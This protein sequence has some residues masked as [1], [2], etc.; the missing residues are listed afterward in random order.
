MHDRLA[1]STRCNDSGGCDV[2]NMMYKPLPR[3]RG[4]TRPL[5]VLV[6]CSI[7]GVCLSA[8]PVLA[9]DTLFLLSSSD[10]SPD[11]PIDERSPLVVLCKADPVRC[12]AVLAERMDALREM[13]QQ[14]RAATRGRTVPRLEEA[15][16]LASVV[17]DGPPEAQDGAAARLAWLAHR[18]RWVHPIPPELELAVAQAWSASPRHSTLRDLLADAAMTLGHDDALD[19][20]VERL[21]PVPPGIWPS[22]APPPMWLLR[23]H[24]DAAAEATSDASLRSW[25]TRNR[26][27]LRFDAFLRRWTI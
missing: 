15:A 17:T 24:T 25:F 1:P 20:L 9:E 16:L 5:A 8:T 23:R 27:H 14:E 10:P 22:D 7:L 6:A 12:R 4:S 11:P 26:D 18:H 3:A 19:H 13:L 21:P 2:I